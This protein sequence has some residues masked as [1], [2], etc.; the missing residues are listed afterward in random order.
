[1]VYKRGTIFYRR[2]IKGLH[3]LSKMVYKRVWVWS[4][5]RAC[6]YPPP[7]G[8]GVFPRDGIISFG[9]HNDEN[10]DMT[11]TK[12]HNHVANPLKTLDIG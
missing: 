11:S 7:Q 5:G 1:M 3:F 6:P 10:S 9:N 12:T 8:R 2:Y 4:S